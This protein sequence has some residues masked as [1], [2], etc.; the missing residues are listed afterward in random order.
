MKDNQYPGYAALA[1]ALI[2]IVPILAGGCGGSSSHSTPVDQSQTLSNLGELG[3]A[4]NQYT[5]DY[6]EHM[7]I[8]TNSTQFK[9]ELMPYTRD[10]SVFVDSNTNLPLVWNASLAGKVI[11]SYPD[12]SVVV[13][14]YDQDPPV[15]NSIPLVLLSGKPETVTDAEFA[16]LKT[17]SGIQ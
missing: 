2:S 11:T 6:D 1:I 8:A 16:Q 14:V 4:V 12:Y 7:P 17:T 13:M 5:I 10:S 3:L 15:D 9:A